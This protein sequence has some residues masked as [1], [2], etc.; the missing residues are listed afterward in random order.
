LVVLSILVA[1]KNYVVADMVEVAVW[2]LFLLLCD[3]H[4]SQL[5]R[6]ISLAVVVVAINRLYE[7]IYF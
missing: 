2:E 4:I 5:H 7:H 6:I 3:G 1:P